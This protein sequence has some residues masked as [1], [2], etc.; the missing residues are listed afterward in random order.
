MLDDIDVIL[1][2]K[3]KL[4]PE[5][6]VL[7]G[8]SGG[9]DS[10]CLADVLRQAGYRIVLGHF[11]H[12]LRPEADD[13]EAA[14][15]EKLAVRWKVTCTTGSGNVRDHAGGNRLSIEAAARELRYH[16]LF[17]A[18]RQH[19]AQ[20]IAVGHTADDQVETVLMHFIRGAGM[21][22]LKGMSYRTF[23]PA[24]DA[25]I[26]I[27]RP[28]L[29]VRRNETIAY[30]A[31]HDLQPHYDPSNDSL[32]FLRNRVRHELVPQL[33]TYNPR[34]R[35]AVLRS[36]RTIADDQV[37]LQDALR[38][39]WESAVIRKT[40]EYVMFDAPYLSVQSP[41]LQRHLVRQAVT[42]L[43][44]GEETD[45]AMLERASAFLSNPDRT[46]VDL[47]GG[48][49]LF[50]EK[51]TFFVTKSGARLPTE[52]WPQLP[53]E[54]DAVALPVPGQIRLVGDWSFSSEIWADP[55]SARVASSKNGDRFRVW[56]DAEELPEKLEVRI[57]RRGDVFE[58]LG[59]GGHSQKLSDFFTNA[60]LP[61]RARDRWP[62]LSIG[63]KI[64]WIPG[65]RPAE[66][67]KLRPASKRVICFTCKFPENSKN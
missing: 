12:K 55:A 28:L 54:F 26:P 24:F 25:E 18:A 17:K 8:V 22:G 67:F 5:R 14:A 61:R 11:N 7:V 62:L 57:R 47:T 15:V 66:S 6:A 35:E 9:P 60:K 53:A 16:F 46:R 10:L 48:L 59:L 49:S 23:L 27:V 40:D 3:C 56:I 44:P 19:D 39:W 52:K 1:R 58:P 63:K 43:L 34:V 21:N 50:R 30:C 51:G 37:L 41:N 4:V 2:D 65:C 45:H 13:E 31:G 36:S 42:C 33:E 32:D 64:I 29:D 20:A 38:I